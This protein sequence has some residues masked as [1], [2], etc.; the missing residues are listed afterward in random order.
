[1]HY[2]Y[3]AGLE[4]TYGNALAA[5]GGFHRVTTDEGVAAEVS[6]HTYLWY[7]LS[8]E[9]PTQKGSP[10]SSS[11]SDS[12]PLA[13]TQLRIGDEQPPSGQEDAWIKLD[14]S[15]DRQKGRFLWYQA[16]QFQPPTSPS[17]QN[18]QL[19]PLNEIRVVRDLND[20]PDGFESLDEPL[21]SADDTGSKW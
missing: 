12:A 18:K 17:A 9:A 4:V 14:K 2:E 5:G 11:N 10:P 7:K 21:L 13:I 1:M 20:A 15:V 19:M 8:S 3:V 6:P 16:S